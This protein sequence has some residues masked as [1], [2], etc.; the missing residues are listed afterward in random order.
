MSPQTD[1][2]VA[3]LPPRRA[4]RARGGLVLLPD[5]PS[6]NGKPRSHL[7]VVTHR[8]GGWYQIVCMGSGKRCVA[9]ECKHTAGLGFQHGDRVRPIKQA[10]R[11]VKP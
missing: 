11:E 1:E 9:G 4:G 8:G 2:R 6:K 5:T 3:P 10:P 7:A